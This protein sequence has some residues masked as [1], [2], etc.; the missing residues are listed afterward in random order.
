MK[1]YVLGFAFNKD[2]D[3]VVM[4]KKNRPDWQAGLWNGVGGKVDGD[5]L[6]H[7]AMVREFHEETGVITRLG[8]WSRVGTIKET[9]KD[10]EVYVFTSSDDDYMYADT[11]TDEEIAILS[12]NCIVTGGIDVIDNIPFLLELCRC[13]NRPRQ[14]IIKY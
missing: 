4:I 8:D 12:V 13:N 5:E 2:K 1:K 10:A 14:F 11:K 6:P 9:T 7:N 3:Y